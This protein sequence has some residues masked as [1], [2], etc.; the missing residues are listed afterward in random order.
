MCLTLAIHYEYLTNPKTS[1]SQSLH[2]LTFSSNYKIHFWHLLQHFP[3]VLSR[4][5]WAVCGGL[6]VCYFHRINHIYFQICLTV[7]SYIYAHM[8]I[9]IC[10]CSCNCCSC[11]EVGHMGK[12]LYHRVCNL[13]YCYIMW[14]SAFSLKSFEN[15]FYFVYR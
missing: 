14:Y 4:K 6:A 11:I 3:A 1:G 15:Y 10:I 13:W 2:I 8:Y 9:K 12:I 5:L 7:S